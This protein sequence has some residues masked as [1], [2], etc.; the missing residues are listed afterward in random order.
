MQLLTEFEPGPQETRFHRRNRDSQSIGGFFRGKFFDVPQNK[1]NPEIRLE[2][3]NDLRQDLAYFRLPKALL[4]AGP[5]VLHFPW[6]EVILA[7]HP[8]VQRKFIRPPFA[9]AP[10]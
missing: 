1:D 10:E 3:I 2:L 4:P 8:F 6:H 5:P 9:P 7:P